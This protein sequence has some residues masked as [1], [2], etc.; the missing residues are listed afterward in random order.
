MMNDKS[1]KS[2]QAYDPRLRPAVWLLACA[3]VGSIALG[4]LVTGYG[5]QA[6][7]PGSSDA[8]GPNIFGLFPP[9][10]WFAVWD[11]FLEHGHRI[12]GVLLTL[13]SAGLAVALWRHPEV[14]L[15]WMAVAT[16]AAVALESTLG[17]LRVIRD[18][19]LLAKLHGCTAPLV[20]ALC[21]TM[22]ILTSPLWPDRKR[23]AKVTVAGRLKWLSPVVASG[24]FLQTVLGVQLRHLPL[25]DA[26]G[27]FPFWVWLH[28]IAAG[29]VLA[30]L[31]WLV[32]LAFGG[33]RDQPIIVRRVKLLT[34]LYVVQLLLGA[35][36]W[37]TNY[38]WPIWFKDYVWPL[39]NTVVAQGWLQMAVTTG[40]VVVGSL[41]LATALS[42][43]FCIFRPPSG[44]GDRDW[45]VLVPAYCKR[46]VNGI[47]RP[48]N[49]VANHD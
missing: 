27:W 44:G 29:S 25:D 38:G 26:P 12:L 48:R 13:I 23:R 39:N 47:T 3:T 36:A 5:A 21:V 7:V 43:S 9:G 6:A 15:R 31:V 24:I 49:T 1:D 4:G 16:M 22:L 17:G 30:G 14:R 42:L 28:L 18:D 11:V 32:L 40:H 46:L 2:A 37:V 20:L 8:G 41:S 34:T 19:V 10:T 45:L 35:A 33:L